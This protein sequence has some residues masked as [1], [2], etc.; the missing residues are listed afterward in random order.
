MVLNINIETT[1]FWLEAAQ[2]GQF[3]NPE[4]E[5]LSINKYSD[6]DLNDDPNEG[7][8]VKVVKKTRKSKQ[9]AY[10]KKSP[11]QSS[12]SSTWKGKRPFVGGLEIYKKTM[13]EAIEKGIKFLD[14]KKAYSYI[15]LDLTQDTPISI[16]LDNGTTKI[17]K[18]HVLHYGPQIPGKRYNVY[19][20]DKVWERIGFKKHPFEEI[21]QELFDR[22][23]WLRD[24]SDPLKSNKLCIIL[25]KTSPG[26]SKKHLWH[27]YG[28]FN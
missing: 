7:L 26:N 21:Q 1:L 4:I 22:G 14:I 24:E 25:Y 27:G 2:E 6:K 8:W 13:Y 9:L 11:T 19:K 5:A 15:N 28:G 16:N 12:Q 3:P 20:R 17:Y 10:N 18:F 23:Y